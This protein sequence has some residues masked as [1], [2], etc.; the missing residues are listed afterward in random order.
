MMEY[1]CNDWGHHHSHRHSA[2]FPMVNLSIR[3]FAIFCLC[4]VWIMGGATDARQDTQHHTQTYR[5]THRRCH[6]ACGKHA[7][8][9][10]GAPPIKLNLRY[11]QEEHLRSKAL[12]QC[13]GRLRGL[14]VRPHRRPSNIAPPCRQ[15]RHPS[16]GSGVGRPARFCC[17]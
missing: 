11:E 15:H 7:L 2:A 17:T 5:H 4:E 16:G 12:P 10:Q 3:C 6:G 13:P 1:G 9:V 14:V 8:F